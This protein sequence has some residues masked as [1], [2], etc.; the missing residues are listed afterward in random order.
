MPIYYVEEPITTEEKEKAIRSWKL[1]A[2]GQAAEFYRLKKADPVNIPCSSPME[3]FGNRFIQ[4]FF[5][6]HPI[7]APMFSKTSMKQG[8]LFFRMIA[9]TIA[10]LDNDAKFDSQ[11]VTLAKSHN[12]MGIRAVEY[13]IFGECLFWVLKLTLGPEYDAMTHMGWVKIFSRVLKAMVPVAIEY[14]IENKE[15][16]K[17]RVTSRFQAL[18]S[19]LDRQASSKANTLSA[20]SDDG[21]F[22]TLRLMEE[23]RSSTTPRS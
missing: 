22:S 11:F 9:F 2:S 13:G 17:S 4:R 6:V 15:S 23:Q 14:E 1:V 20:T 18:T 10:A 12:R 5:E 16:M 3:F 7:A 8:T 21:S 19:T